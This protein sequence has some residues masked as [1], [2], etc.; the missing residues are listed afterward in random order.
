[1]LTVAALKSVLSSKCVI[2]AALLAAAIGGQQIRYLSLSAEFERT[3]TRYA[4]AVIKSQDV[5]REEEARRDDEWKEIQR[6]FTQ[7]RARQDKIRDDNLAR[8]A[9]SSHGLRNQLTL[10]AGGYTLGA[11]SASAGNCE[12]ALAARS[13]VL[14]SCVERYSAMAAEAERY[15][16]N[17]RS[18]GHEC[19]RH[20]DSLNGGLPAP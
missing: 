15:S 9:S 10:P 18:A 8:L 1:M 11:N 6:E 12:A 4:M 14:S 17:S 16:D 7:L 13:A 20:H 2:A 3:K 5:A 19:E